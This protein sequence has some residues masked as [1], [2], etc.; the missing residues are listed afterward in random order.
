MWARPRAP[1]PSRAMPIFARVG[2]ACAMAAGVVAAEGSCAMD[3]FGTKKSNRNGS[4]MSIVRFIGPPG[5]EGARANWG[6]LILLGM[7][8]A[9]YRFKGRTCLLEAGCRHRLPGIG[10]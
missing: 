8:K 10:R 4:A 5:D 9:F 6:A 1:P 7:M 2:L 3:K